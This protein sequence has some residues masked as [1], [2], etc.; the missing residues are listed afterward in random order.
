MCGFEGHRDPE[1]PVGHRMR[2]VC[3]GPGRSSGG[4]CRAAV[5][6]LALPQWPVKTVACFRGLSFR[7]LVHM[8]P[9]AVPRAPA[10]SSTRP[11]LETAAPHE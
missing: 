1:K 11:A 9:W 4:M 3:W 5:L 2:C 8:A 7:Q 6:A 10:S